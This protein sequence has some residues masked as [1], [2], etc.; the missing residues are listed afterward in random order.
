MPESLLKP[1]RLPHR[2]GRSA[3][4]PRLRRTSSVSLLV[5]GRSLSLGLTVNEGGTEAQE[6]R[7][8]QKGRGQRPRHN[9]PS[10][11]QG[12]DAAAPTAGSLS[13]GPPP[14][15]KNLA[16]PAPRPAAPPRGKNLPSWSPS[17]RLD[18]SGPPRTPRDAT[19]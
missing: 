1:T 13:P 8:A 11:P 14:S 6:V 9:R 4:R 7:S 17:L 16:S 10:P 18:E 15:R 3:V 2:G 12:A 19:G 5:T